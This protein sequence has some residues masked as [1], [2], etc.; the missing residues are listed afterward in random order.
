MVFDD[1]IYM[2]SVWKVHFKTAI[3]GRKSVDAT[4]VGSDSDC[5][6][7]RWMQSEGAQKFA[8]KPGFQRA[9]AVHKRFHQLAA[10]VAVAINRKDFETAEKLVGSS[11][12]YNAASIE[13]VNALTEIDG[14]MGLDFAAYLKNMPKDHRRAP[15]AA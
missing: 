6:L 7:G 2:H 5:D 4:E 1:P 14:D 9:V 3:L 15:P 11:G 10:E 8:A 12:E 13:M